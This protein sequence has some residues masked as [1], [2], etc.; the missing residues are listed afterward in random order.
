MLNFLQACS[1]LIAFNLRWPVELRNFLTSTGFAGG[2]TSGASFIDCAL[3]WNAYQQQLAFLVIPIVV[4]S[5]PGLIIGALVLHHRR[6][7]VEW[8]KQLGSASE[9]DIDSMP[10]PPALKVS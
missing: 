3:K 1:V 10:P 8:Q 5:V 4:I 6:M 9:S 7:V 2:M